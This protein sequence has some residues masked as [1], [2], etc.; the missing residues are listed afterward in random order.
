L[1]FPWRTFRKLLFMTSSRRFKVKKTKQQG[2]SKG[3]FNLPLEVSLDHLWVTLL[4]RSLPMGKDYAEGL[5]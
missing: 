1:R 5:L 3:A 2:T 4:H